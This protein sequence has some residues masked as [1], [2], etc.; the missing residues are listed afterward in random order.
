MVYKIVNNFLS[1]VKCQ[2]LIDKSESLGYTEADISYPTGAVMKKEYRN[3]SRCL[4]R[5]EKLRVELENMILPHAPLVLTTIK[6]GGVLDY[7]KFIKLSGNFRFYKYVTGEEFKRHRDG[8]QL[9][10]GGVSLVTVLIYLNDVEEGGETSL[11]DRMLESPVMV[12]PEEGKLLIF[13]HTILHAGLPLIK[14]VKY[15]LRTDLIYNA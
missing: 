9:E 13:E 5:D 6:E 12:K 1:P 2:E 7:K 15:V 10:E 3:N 4:C 11:C 14:G 8:N